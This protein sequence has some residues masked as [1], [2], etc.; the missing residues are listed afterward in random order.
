VSYPNL[1][2]QN[3]SRLT[4]PWAEFIS[5]RGEAVAEC[6]FG[7][8]GNG[9][10]ATITLDVNFSDVA[11]NLKAGVDGIGGVFQQL[12]GYAVRD[13]DDSGNGI[14]RR[15]LPAAHP[16]I[17][18]YFCSRVSRANFYGPNG[19]RVQGNPY[20]SLGPMA[21]W[22]NCRITALFD[23]R[24]YPLLTDQQLLQAP[25]NGNELARFC[26]IDM[27]PTLTGFQ[28]APGANYGFQWPA[29]TQVGGSS[30]IR[31]G[32]TQFLARAAVRITW[33]QVPEA[34]IYAPG[35]FPGLVGVPTLAWTPLT[36]V[37]NDTFI[38]L[39]GYLLYEAPKIEP[40]P[41][42]FPLGSNVNLPQ[43]LF[44]VSYN[45][46]YSSKPWRQVPNPATG[47]WQTIQITPPAGPYLYDD[48]TFGNYICK[49]L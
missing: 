13:T 23:A 21:D 41:A 10:Q 42:P 12:V 39:P 28:R 24:P 14:I 7:W 47:V 1:K 11:D 38:A 20:P 33:Y 32:V 17:P 25:Y 29:G 35:P 40:V 15:Q 49:S 19:K 3:L 46:R 45:L 4:M 22:R 30:F 18:N 36:C 2:P 27:D 34:S 31:F 26:T 9:A 43:R 8:G 6:S 5:R 44:N 16:L 48:A 37:N